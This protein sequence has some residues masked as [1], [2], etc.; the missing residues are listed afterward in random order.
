MVKKIYL[1]KLDRNICVILI[2]PM[3][4][5]LQAHCCSALVLMHHKCLC[6]CCTL[7]RVMVY[8][9]L[10]LM[11]ALLRSSLSELREGG[12]GGT[13]SESSSELSSKSSPG[14]S[15]E[16]PGAL[17]HSL[18]RRPVRSTCS[19]YCVPSHQL[20][21]AC[22]QDLLARHLELVRV[23]VRGRSL[24]CLL[25]VIPDCKLQVTRDNTLLLVIT[26]GITK[27]LEN[28]RSQVLEDGHKID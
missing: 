14:S 7:T 22:S 13:P 3:P 5:H 18:S 11:K 6:C 10:P 28:L 8:L 15:S 19:L 9:R 12:G 2:I 17:G 23:P 1:F 21:S 24:S 4:I 26:S 16:W 27:Q 20:V 25:F